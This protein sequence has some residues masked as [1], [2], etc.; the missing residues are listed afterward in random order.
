MKVVITSG[1]FNP[2]HGG[3]L[4][5]IQSASALGDKLIVST[6]LI[7]IIKLQSII[8]LKSLDCLN[9]IKTILFI[10]FFR[11]VTIPWLVFSSVTKSAT[12]SALAIE[13]LVS[14][15]L[16]PDLVLYKTLCVVDG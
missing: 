2:L 16:L 12:I 6:I 13:L 5:L 9:Q 4:D 10:Y 8:S 1:F 3:H 14:K 7:S 11:A 15:P